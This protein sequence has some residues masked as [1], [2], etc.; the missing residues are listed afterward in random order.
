MFPHRQA[1]PLDGAEK[2][3]IPV[4]IDTEK[5]G[6]VIFSAFTVPLGDKKFWLEDRRTGIFTNLNSNTYT[7]N[8]PIHH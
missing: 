7:V 4:G 6:E 5:G 2:N 3:I 8:L 1:L